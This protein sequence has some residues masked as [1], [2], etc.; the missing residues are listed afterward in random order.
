VILARCAAKIGL[1]TPAKNS[2]RNSAV[3]MT[4]NPTTPGGLTLIQIVQR[5]RAVPN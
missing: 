5:V 1:K 3:R 4:T 2:S